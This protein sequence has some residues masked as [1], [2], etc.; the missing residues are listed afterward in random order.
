MNTAEPHIIR[1]RGPWEYTLLS[2]LR[3]GEM[4]RIDLE[5]NAPPPWSGERVS[6]RLTRYFH[7]PTGITAATSVHLM[8]RDFPAET[9]ILLDGEPLTAG[10][11]GNCDLTGRLM[12]RHRLDLDLPVATELGE[13]WL[14]IWD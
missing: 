5:S 13:V 8:V 1:L 14:E 6:V 3:A 2:G 7:S 12:R 11:S 9:A 10:D 4:G